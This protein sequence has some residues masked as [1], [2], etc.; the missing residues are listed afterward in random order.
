MKLSRRTLMV[1]AGLA[2]AALAIGARPGAAR[3]ADG[4]PVPRERDTT[5]DLTSVVVVAPDVPEWQAL[6]GEVAD[7]IASSGAPRPE[8]R[9]PDEQRFSAGWAG[10]AILLGHLGNNVEIARFYGMRYAMVDSW[11]PGPSGFWALTIV[12]P[13]ALGGNS[14][15]IGAS[16]LDGARAGVEALTPLLGAGTSLPWQHRV[17]L[18]ASVLAALSNG[19]RTDEDYLVAQRADIDARVA[20]L[21]PTTGVETDAVVL[22]GLLARVKLMGEAYLISADTGF[23]EIYRKAL[24]AYSQFLADHPTEATDQ[25]NNSRNMWPSGPGVIAV[26]A[27]TEFDEAF[28]AADR[29][30]ILA[31]LRITFAANF[32]DGYLRSA[33]PSGPRWNHEAYPALS[34]VSGADYFWRQH[35]LPEAQDWMERGAVIFTGNTAVISLD[36]GADYLMH[37][38]IITMDY[39]MFTGQYEYLTRTLRPSADLNVLMVDNCGAM[40][41]GGD[42]YPYGYSGLYS[43][44]HSAVMNAAN[45]LFAEPIYGLLLE[46][47]RTG[48]FKDQRMPDLDF[49]LHRYTVTDG[50]GQRE[51]Q[52]PRTPTTNE[53]S[54]LPAVMAYPVEAG[55]YDDIAGTEEV[56]VP[57][58]RTFHKMAFRAG[59]GIDQ[60]TLMLDGFA[61]GRH[62]HQDGNA[63]I[64]YTA[65]Q[66]MLLVDRDYMEN[67][68]EHHTGL[69]VVRDGEQ[70]VKGSF[71]EVEWVAD[72]DGVAI[73]R[74]RVAEWNG[75]DW[76]RTVIA[77]DDA[78]HVVVDDLM[79]T[80]D[81]RYLVKNQWQTLGV[82]SLT[83][84]RYTCRQDGVTMSID[85]LDATQLQIADRRGHFLKYYRST[86]P[87]PYAEAETVLTQVVAERARTA[88]EREQ[89]VNVIGTAVGEAVDLSP[90]RITERLWQVGSG[91]EDWWFVTGTIDAAGLVSDA[92]VTV[93]GPDRVVL[94]G[95]TSVA[96]DGRE[97]KFGEP[98]IWQLDVAGSA[99]Q[100]YP[101]RRD[102]AQYDVV[103]NPV[104]PGPIA[105]GTQVWNPGRSE[106]VVGAIKS[107]G[108]R[109]RSG[110]RTAA[111]PA[112]MPAGWVQGA[113]VD[114]E[115]TAV[116]PGV[117]ANPGSVLI[118][119][120]DGRVSHLSPALAVSWTYEA[121][122]RV[123]E[124]ATQT[125]GD[126]K[127]V[128]VATED[129]QVHALGAGDGQQRWTTKIP[130]DAARREIKGNLLGVTAVRTGYVNGQDAAPQLMVGTQFRYVY[131]LTWDGKI[132][133]TTM[134]YFYGIEDMVFADLDGDG[135][136][137]GAIALE[138]FYPSIWKA[139]KEIRGGSAGGA[140]FTAVALHRPETGSPVII[141]GTKQNAVRSYT[142]SGSKIVPGW[143]RNVSGQV[144]GLDCGT[145]HSGVGAE[146]VLGTTGFDVWSL[147][148]D[149]APRFRTP[150]G[151]RIVQVLPV[152][153]QGY[154]VAADHGLLVSLD[155]QGKETGRWSFPSAIAGLV[156]GPSPV[157]VLAD[158]RVV[159]RG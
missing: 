140:G 115:V 55:V 43:W 82:G 83:G 67:T 75:T 128:T 148:M 74:T 123:N 10:H 142:F 29:E 17:S 59:L 49:P 9:I 84:G 25:L 155:Q 3:A 76:V 139:G 133:S 107:A 18:S 14:L 116:A 8:V 73:S 91:S 61:G 70:G 98:V 35:Q 78:F 121:D 105:D 31:G 32:N 158:G 27:L 48:P 154:L 146:I 111:E 26:W 118:G 41:G 50:T 137:E 57:R 39:A 21:K 19:G 46:R 13:F 114:G 28:T 77:V 96:I 68:P 62:N 99:W 79:I 110:P 51:G 66:R 129:Y 144:T 113:T 89:F 80:T 125:H 52:P 93:L 97:E 151:D 5:I 138:Y 95:A 42:V 40:V 60:P 130:D 65:R 1:S 30:L 153:D 63:I 2:G 4:D 37:L 23:F 87:Y 6:A 81:G 101:V 44:G 90:Q 112:T 108:R 11:L 22:H 45:W 104:R 134:H 141:Y 12:D 92:T 38:P 109:W 24:L 124:V 88:G 149:G 145:F 100:A 56:S 150:I 54:G 72:V 64:G 159:R 119:T 127:L 34:L 53:E 15:V 94:A 126:A 117:N 132:T 85:S 136:D 122:S 20:A 152:S 7:A 16:D 157:V 86:N 33:R 36:E 58:E 47:L 131:G 106:R 120:A 71:T 147:S 135:K 102:L 69:V 143:V 103:G 156:A